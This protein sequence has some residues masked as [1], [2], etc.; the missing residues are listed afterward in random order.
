MSVQKVNF[1]PVTDVL[2]IN[3]RDIPLA[4]KAL[5]NPTNPLVLTDGEWMTQNS[6]YK[7]VRAADVTSAGDPS[8]FK[9]A[10]PLWMEAGRYDVQAMADRKT[11]VLW[12]GFYEY[13]TLIFDPAAT[14]GTKGTAIAAYG[15]PLKVAQITIGARDYVGLVGSNVDNAEAQ[16]SI[17]GYVSKLHGDNGGWLRF[18][19]ACRWG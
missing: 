13:E 14:I 7:L 3:R 19:C 11:A 1:R 4:D 12:G 16:S 8:L 2:P 6:S 9:M 18:R 10:F 15:Q 17:V 5:A